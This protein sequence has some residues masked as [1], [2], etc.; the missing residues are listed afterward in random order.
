MNKVKLW[1][2]SLILFH[3]SFCVDSL[4]T[5]WKYQNYKHHFVETWLRLIWTFYQTLDVQFHGFS[6]ITIINL[7]KH[8]QNHVFSSFY[9]SQT[10]GYIS[11]WI[12]HLNFIKIQPKISQKHSIKLL[13][14]TWPKW[15]EEE[16]KAFL[17]PK[18]RFKLLHPNYIKEACK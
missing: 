10:K 8:H 1:V 9:A 17:C 5:I 15:K 18:S 12:Q 2:V 7:I 6:R 11:I 16:I 13:P 3:T 14:Y 4:K